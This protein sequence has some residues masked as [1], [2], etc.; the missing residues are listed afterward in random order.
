VEVLASRWR[1]ESV[2]GMRRVATTKIVAVVSSVRVAQDTFTRR[3]AV[4]TITFRSERK[5]SRHAEVITTRSVS[6]ACVCMEP[7]RSNRRR[8]GGGGGGSGRWVVGVATRGEQ[9]AGANPP[10]Y[11]SATR[12]L[13]CVRARR[14]SRPCSSEVVSMSPPRQ[15]CEAM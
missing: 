6:V 10:V 5:L 9:K 13:L 8:V 1:P 15:A 4:P 11:A 14:C 3:Y 2:M 12:A 7:R